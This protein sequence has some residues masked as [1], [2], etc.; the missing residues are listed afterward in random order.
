MKSA[1]IALFIGA[2][3]WCYPLMMEGQFQPCGALSMR[4]LRIAARGDPKLADSFTAGM[5][6]FL[7]DTV[8]AARVRAARPASP[9]ELLCLEY[10]WLSM[11]DETQ[12]T[13]FGF[14]LHSDSAQTQAPSPVGRA[15]DPPLHR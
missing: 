13:R 4:A 7:G 3:I 2:A 1:L 12:L 10:Y 11:V 6:S 9:P 8:L 15:I 5:V 14:N